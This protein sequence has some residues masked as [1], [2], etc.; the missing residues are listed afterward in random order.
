MNIHKNARLTPIG[1]ERL[2]MAVLSGQTPEA[3]ARAASVCPRTARKWVKR[4]QAEGQHVVAPFQLPL[5]LQRD[6]G[7]VQQIAGQ[8]TAIRGGQEDGRLA[9]DGQFHHQ[10]RRQ[11][12]EDTKIGAGLMGKAAPRPHGAGRAFAVTN[13]NS[14]TPASQ[15]LGSCGRTR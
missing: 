8:R 14:Q 11:T 3:A 4:F 10:N 13:L 7:Q 5:D 1:R 2:A 12:F 15:A 9:P 6:G